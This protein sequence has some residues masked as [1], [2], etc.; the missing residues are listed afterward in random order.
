L[1]L[2]ELALVDQERLDPQ[3]ELLDRLPL[4]TWCTSNAISPRTKRR[5][6]AT[7]SNTSDA[8]TRAALIYA[9]APP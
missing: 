7:T 4:P 3:Y 2:D 6:P 8:A 9:V 1:R 5:A